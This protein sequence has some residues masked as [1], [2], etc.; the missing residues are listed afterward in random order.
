MFIV[1]VTPIAKGGLEQLSYFSS[2]EFAIGSVIQVPLRKKEIPALV[3]RIEDARAIKS[4][5][6]TNMYETRKVREQEAVHVFSTAFIRSTNTTASYYATSIGGILQSYVPS[7]ILKGAEDGTLPQQATTLHKGNGF[8]KLVLQ[9]CKANRI[10][11]YKT[12]IRSNFAKGNSVFLCTATVREARLFA[13]EYSKGIEKYTFLLE[14][15]QSPK[16][17]KEV[18][19]QALAEKHPVLIV[20]TPVFSSIPREDIGMFILENEMSSSYKQ[21]ARPRVDARI[22]IENTAREMKCAL[23]YAG[24]TVSLKVHRELQS[25]FAR[26]LEERTLKLRTNSSLRIVDTKAA[27]TYAKENKREFPILTQ[28]S[29]LTLQDAVENNEHAFVFAARRGIASQTVCNDCNTTVTCFHCKSPVVLHNRGENRELLCHRCGTTRDAHE[30]CT[31]CNSWNLVPLG[32]GIERIEEYIKA[33]IPNALILTLNSDVAKTPTQAKKIVDEF[34]AQKGSILIGT[35]MALSYLTKEVSC[36]VM[37]SI[38]S[39]LCVPDFRIEERIFSIITI[40]REQT[41]KMLIVETSSPD[42]SM[43]KH[44]RLGSL[45][46]YAQEELILR[47][48]L[49]YPPYTHLIKVTFNGTRDV[50]IRNMQKFA[51]LTEKFKPRIFAGFI[52]RGPNLELHALIRSPIEKWPDPELI[53]ILT[54]LPQTTIVD[55]D[56]ERTL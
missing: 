42:N 34:Y 7:A 6:R 19:V 18:W 55:I 48:K 41:E 45:S 46:E 53:A 12:I 50:V 20:A 11:K 23:V 44:A 17:Q 36:S 25:G 29:V 56:P 33:Q 24:T 9:L 10:E 5:L 14:S 22:L 21:Q 51:A 35:E 43:L 26:E 1:H 49:H 52:P 54:A 27:R 47:K 38:D 31:N 28:D 8:E 13:E 3:H 30:T 2:Q 4:I 39:L 37:S 16:K 40:L 32:I 15:T